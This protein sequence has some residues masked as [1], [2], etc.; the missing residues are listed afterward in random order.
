MNVMF[1]YNRYL[2]LLLCILF[3]INP[4]IVSQTYKDSHYTYLTTINDLPS[5]IDAGPIQIPL[6]VAFNEGGLKKIKSAI[7]KIS[8][9]T[10]EIYKYGNGDDFQF[11]FS[12]QVDFMLNSIGSV[13]LFKPTPYTLSINNHQPT[14]LFLEDFSDYQDSDGQLPFESFEIE[15][16]DVSTDSDMDLTD[17]QELINDLQI[18]VIYDIEYGIDV[19]TLPAPVTS[20]LTCVG[21]KSVVFNWNVG[22][23]QYPSFELQVL[24]L[25]NNNKEILE[26]LSEIRADIDWSKALSIL[27]ESSISSQQINLAEGT[28]FYVCRVRGIGTYYYGGLGNNENYGPW[29]NNSNNSNNIYLNRTEVTDPF[30]FFTDPDEHTNWIYSRTFS[31]GNKRSEEITFANNLLQIKQTQSILPTTG[32][33]LIKQNLHDKSGRPALTTMPIPVE[34]HSGLSYVDDFVRTTDNDL[35]TNEDFDLENNFKNPSQ[36]LQSGTHFSYFSENNTDI[37]I[38]DAQG[39]PY[40]RNLFYN[41]GTDRIYEKS[42]F[43]QIHSLSE[44]QTVN[45]GRTVRTYYSTASDQE[46][47]MLFGDEAPNHESVLKTITVD[48]NNVANISYN[49]LDGNTLATAISFFENGENNLLGLSDESSSTNMQQIEDVVTKNIATDNGFL[50]SKRLTLLEE[51]QL[52]IEYSIECKT[53]TEGCTSVDLD[54]NFVLEIVVQNITDPTWTPIIFNDDLSG[55]CDM[56]ENIKTASFTI[57]DLLP[58]GTYIIEK[59]LIQTSS[60]TANL[61]IATEKIELQVYP[62]S[63]L[64]SGWLEGI[65]CIEQLEGFYEKLRELSDNVIAL[66]PDDFNAFYGLHDFDL[67]PGEHGIILLPDEN[68][69]RRVVIISPCCELDVSVSFVPPLSCPDDFSTV[70]K[71]G[72]GKIDVNYDYLNNPQDSEFSPDFEGYAYAFFESAGCDILDPMD[73]LYGKEEFLIP[74]LPEVHA[75]LEGFRPGDFNWMIYHML[76]DMYK[77]DDEFSSSVTPTDPPSDAG[78]SGI[79]NECD[80]SHPEGGPGITCSGENCTQYTC[81]DLIRCWRGVLMRINN[82]LCAGYYEDLEEDR[83]ISEGVDDENEKDEDTEKHDNHFDENDESAGFFTKLLIDLVISDK[84]RDAQDEPLSVT[85]P[86][87]SGYIGHMVNDF[88][89]CTGYRFAKILTEVDGPF[90]EDLTSGRPYTE[91]DDFNPIDPITDKPYFPGVKDPVFTFKYFTYEPGTFP[92]LEAISCFRDP[93]ICVEEI[94]GVLVEVPCCPDPSN[95]DL[96]NFCGIGQIECTTTEEE[97]SCGQRF[98]FFELL[99]YYHDPELVTSFEVKDCDS[100]YETVDT[101]DGPVTLIRQQIDE[102]ETSCLERCEDRRRSIRDTLIA[103]LQRKCYVIGG[104]RTEDPLT[105]FIIPEEDIDVMVDSIVNQCINQCNITTYAC[106]PEEQ[107]RSIDLPRDSLGHNI[108]YT[109]LDFGVGGKDTDSCVP[110]PYAGP[111]IYKCSGELSY[112]EATLREQ[113]MQWKLEL[114]IPSKCEENIGG[115]EFDE[116]GDDTCV[117]KELLTQPK[118]Y[119]LFDPDN[120]E[121]GDPIISGAVKVEIVVKKEELHE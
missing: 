60:P 58:P 46:L 11:K 116:V 71:N 65:I 100:F 84:I 99:R 20:E 107:C 117:E 94:D 47:V 6:P 73:I 37:S 4:N 75:G 54:C 95:N 13:N 62:L 52:S 106:L 41:D 93:N 21:G 44:I 39:Y 72:N 51:S 67:V 66:S 64:I 50:S 98:T 96:C 15:I 56:E 109:G 18:V 10:G 87:S 88:L 83:T 92:V 79:P 19:N 78:D 36:V 27:T 3:F 86:P 103:V 81:A 38:P 59:K 113:A 1:K 17:Y 48:Q 2:L 34:D 90:V 24:K 70:D 28:G 16:T 121:K 111:E 112:C 85:Q 40:S 7:L 8:L 61:G 101:E 55:D 35:F 115:L 12:T 32:I 104:C 102:L 76:T 91:Y 82:E 97:W 29:S 42:G 31:E 33:A 74:P 89:D 25:N 49:T 45:S 5:Q 80:N 57:S 68:N 118:N 120:I 114:D 108:Q 9:S 14:C 110:D 119:D 26:E 105:S 77:C 22:N 43:G 63:S 23:I 53:L 69:P 30:F